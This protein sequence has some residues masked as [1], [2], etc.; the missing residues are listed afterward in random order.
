MIQRYNRQARFHGF[1]EQGQQQLGTQ[2]FMILGA[3]AL[4]SHCAEMLVRMGVGKLTVVDMDIVEIDN[5][6]RQ[7][8]YDEH[9]AQDMLPK[10]IA[11]QQHLTQINSE[12]EVEALYQELTNTN[13]EEIIAN[14]NPDIVMDG[15]DHFKIRYLINEVCHKLQLPWIYGAAVGSKGTV[16]AIDYQGPCLKCMLQTIPETGESC[17]INGVLPPAVQQVASM[18]VSELLRWL[19]GHGF[20]RKLITLDCFEFNYRTLNIDQLKDSE[21]PVCA[22]GNY[23]LLNQRTENKIEGRCGDVFLFRFNSNTFDHVAY[24]PT[25]VL[26]S[27]PFAK[28]MTYKDYEMTLF[29][30]GR[31][32]VYGI[33]QEGEAEALYHTLL[34]SLK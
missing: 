17:A 9:D 6:H 32:N 25:H 12:V 2:H 34:K 24:L 27:N 4:G 21:C 29:K 22:K 18:Q 28:V 10:V 11:L 23:E 1:G 8:T 3:G 15:M 31:M 26:K 30:D 5:L 14:V 33:Q 13:I 19:S 7:A 20:S 16:Y